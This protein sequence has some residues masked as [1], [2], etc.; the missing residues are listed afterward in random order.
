MSFWIITWSKRATKQLKMSAEILA[1]KFKHKKWGVK[2]I[3]T[4]N[5]VWWWGDDHSTV[6]LVLHGI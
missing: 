6:G 2:N 3:T 1:V 5:Y 4:E